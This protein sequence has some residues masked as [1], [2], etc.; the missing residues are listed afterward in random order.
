M[1]EGFYAGAYWGP[2]RETALECAHR[3]VRFFHLMTPCDPTFA[4]WYRGGRRPPRGTPGFPVI[5]DAAEW[6]Q[7]FLKSVIR[8]DVGR[9]VI[10]DLGFR[11]SLWNAHKERTRINLHCGGYSPHGGPNSCLFE[12]PEEGLEHERLWSLPVLTEVLTCI[13]S[14]WD[15]DSVMAS[16]SEMVSIFDKKDGAVRIGWLT[17]LSRRLGRLPPL[18]APV[19][20]E[21]V[22]EQGWLLTLSPEPMSANNPEHVAHTARVRELL[23]RAGLIQPKA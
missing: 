19:R 20:I 16:S 3:A 10:E 7:L 21:S 18:P 11:Q 2:R 6:E 4:Q 22:G 15:P 9:K 1:P 14:A 13:I 5:Q 8:T 17:Y 12:P 23:D